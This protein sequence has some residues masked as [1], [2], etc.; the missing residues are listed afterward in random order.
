MFGFDKILVVYMLDKL[1]LSGDISL[2]EGCLLVRTLEER[3][4]ALTGGE[5][6]I[7]LIRKMGVRRLFWCRATAKFTSIAASGRWQGYRLRGVRRN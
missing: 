4:P 3:L 5:C 2:E 7:H 1:L 6:G